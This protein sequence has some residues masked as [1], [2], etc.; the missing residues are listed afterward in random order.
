MKSKILLLPALLIAF[1]CISFKAKEKINLNEHAQQKV[2][3]FAKKELNAFLENI[4]AGLEKEHGF[5]K[6]AEFAKAVPGSIYT[7]VGLNNQGQVFAT[8]VYNVVVTVNGEYRSMLT[9]S[10]SNGI[11]KIET[12]GA[13]LLAKELQVIEN[14]QTSA[15]SSEKIMLNVYEKK[16]GFVAY[17]PAGTTIENAVFTPLESAKIALNTTTGKTK[18]TTYKVNEIKRI[19]FN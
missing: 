10:L 4:P 14:R 6:R 5:N 7:I 18:G 3:E 9:V 1:C 13:A 19:L 12:V 16:C 17:K 8:N 11:Y 15:N 2:V